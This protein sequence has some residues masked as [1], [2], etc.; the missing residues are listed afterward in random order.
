MDDDLNV[1]DDFFGFYE[2]DS[3]KSETVVKAIKDI[4]VWCSLSLDDCSDRTARH[5]GESWGNLRL[6]EVFSETQK[7]NVQQ[8]NR[9]CGRDIRFWWAATD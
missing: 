9:K 2:I 4:L 6:S 7:K 1:D 5:Y 8:A 3:I